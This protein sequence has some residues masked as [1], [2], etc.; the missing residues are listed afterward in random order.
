MAVKWNF[1]AIKKRIEKGAE[2]GLTKA[3]E[4]VAAEAI[5]KIKSPPKT[6]RIYIKYNP[7]RIHQASAP[8]EPPA[9]DLGFLAA[10]IHP[11]PTK[12]EGGA[13]VKR[14]NSAADYSAPLEFGTDR[15]APRPFMRPSLLEK[16]SEIEQAIAEEIA[17]V[18][19]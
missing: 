13:L 11:Q 8:G 18:L 12:K 16:K 19:K 17:K 3:G 2:A 10:N 6:G 4:I 7:F 15:I 9:N 5:S 1:E 14:I